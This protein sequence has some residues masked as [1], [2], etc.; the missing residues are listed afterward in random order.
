MNHGQRSRSSSPLSS[1]PSSPCSSPLSL[2]SRTPTPPPGWAITPPPSQDPGEE[3]PRPRKRRKIERPIRTTRCLDL[4]ED[5]AQSHFD[6]TDAIRELQQALR[7]RRKIVVIA[8][9]GISVSAGIPDFRSSNGLFASLKGEHKLK[10]GSGKQLFDAAVYKD[11]DSTSQFH[12]MVCKLSKMSQCAKPT[13]FHHMVARLATEG[14]LLRLYTQNVDGLETQMPPLG[15]EVPLPHKG[16]WPQSVQLHGGLEKMMCQKCREIMNFDP[17]L[18]AGS[19]TPSCPKCQETDDIR[20]NDLGRRSH[21]IGRLRPRIVLYNEA[22]PD[23]EAIGAVSAADMRTR[24]DAIVVVG[25]SMKIPG[26]RRI[27]S[28]MCKIVRGRREG[29]AIWINPDPEPTGP[30]FEDCWDL[31]VKGHSDQVADLVNLRRWDDPIEENPEAPTEYTDND[32][33]R[34]NARQGQV[35]VN[36]PPSPLK[37]NA[38]P[39]GT[40]AMTPPRSQSGESQE[41]PKSGQ[42]AKNVRIKLLVGVKSEIAEKEQQSKQ[43]QVNVP[44]LVKNPASNGRKL[45]DVLGKDDAVEKKP[46]KT[47]FKRKKPTKPKAGANHQAQGKLDAKITKARSGIKASSP[48]KRDPSKTQKSTSQASMASA[49]HPSSQVPMVTSV[50]AAKALPRE[51]MDGNETLML[52]RAFN[53]EDPQRASQPQQLSGISHGTVAPDTPIDKPSLAGWN[54]V[55]VSSGSTPVLMSGI[56]TP[57]GSPAPQTPPTSS[58]GPHDEGFKSSAFMHNR[59]E[60]ISPKGNVPRDMMK[61]LN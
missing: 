38:K 4:T 7:N 27:V 51:G 49:I 9:A 30:Q 53:G 45:K 33:E 41:H 37:S 52:Q 58:H 10:G 32:L 16:P 29:T 12:E 6:R 25:T 50:P 48:S 44:K 17:E 26:V 23:D 14:R 35:V 31:I 21:G 11:A 40:A 3:I 46:S 1:V 28:E 61:L 39:T 5:T 18:F 56:T 60:T 22:N 47:S 54:V 24:P 20:T 36:V 42:S 43:I 13:R 57:Y 15:T 19:E 55:S 34:I 8:G 59:R 2:A